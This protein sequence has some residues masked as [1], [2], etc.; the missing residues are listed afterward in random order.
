MTIIVP[1]DRPPEMPKGPVKWTRPTLAATFSQFANSANALIGGRGFNHVCK[2]WTHDQDGGRN[3]LQSDP[4]AESVTYNIRFNQIHPLAKSVAMAIVYQ[5]GALSSGSGSHDPFIGVKMF[6]LATNEVIDP[7]V[8]DG[9]NA[10]ELS[11]SNG[12]IPGGGRSRDVYLDPAT[13]RRGNLYEL[14][15]AYLMRDSGFQ[16][17][18]PTKGRR[19]YYY[20]KVGRGDGVRIQVQAVAVRIWKIVAFEV[21]RTTIDVGVAFGGLGGG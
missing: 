12:A 14:R 18:T 21:P 10:I 3:N 19:L 20:D 7:F 17:T 1:V 16:A 11:G 8:D 4:F 5:G 9:T 6:N 15:T 2:S 13:N